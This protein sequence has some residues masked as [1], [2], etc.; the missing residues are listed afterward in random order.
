MIG[1]HHLNSLEIL[2][3]E[4]ILNVLIFKWAQMAHFISVISHMLYVTFV[5][6]HL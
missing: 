3:I 6:A 2:K 1:R 5:A 4:I